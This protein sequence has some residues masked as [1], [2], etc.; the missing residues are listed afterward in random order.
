[1]KKKAKVQKVQATPRFKQG[2]GVASWKLA[3]AVVLALAVGVGGGIAMNHAKKKPTLSDY[4]L[5]LEAET[6]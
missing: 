4:E 3:A 6:P 5:G 1:M 2:T